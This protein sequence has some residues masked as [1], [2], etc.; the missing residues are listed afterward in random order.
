[1]ADH[2]KHVKT[3]NVLHH[4]DRPGVGDHVGEAAGG[5]S[6]VLAGAAIGS[7]GGPIGTLIGGIAGA[8][9]G[10]WTGR[11]VSEAATN[12]THGDDD[13]YR[14]HYEK[15][16]NRLA[17]RSYDHVRP[18]YHLGHLA[19]HNPDYKDRDWDYVERDLQ[20]GCAPDTNRGDWTSVRDYAREGWTR[21]RSN[22]GT[23]RTATDRPYY[24]TGASM[25]DRAEGMADRAGDAARNRGR[26]V[27]DAADNLKDRVDGNPASRPGPD[28]TDRRI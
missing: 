7:A 23:A 3:N 27:S 11:T 20:T 17:D 15:S 18:A 22:V 28:A 10:W 25:G 13:Y 1:M 9:T 6:G 21:G 12:I 2:D 24:G 16:P 8:M 14:T 26:E 19:A 5:I 4:D